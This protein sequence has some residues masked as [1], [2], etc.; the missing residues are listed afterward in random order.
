MRRFLVAAFGPR[1][2]VVVGP[3]GRRCF[4]WV[5]R[6]SGP[7]CVVK[8][9]RKRTFRGRASCD[10]CVGHRGETFVVFGGGRDD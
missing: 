8:L 3:V 10:D 4:G 2:R 5:R 9:A 7:D 6:R 1:I